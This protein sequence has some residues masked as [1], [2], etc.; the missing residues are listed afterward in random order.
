MCHVGNFPLSFRPSAGWREERYDFHVPGPATLANLQVGPVTN[1]RY[2]ALPG[3]S[4]HII[5][6]ASARA[7]VAPDGGDNEF[8]A[9]VDGIDGL[10]IKLADGVPSGEAHITDYTTIAGSE[11]NDTLGARCSQTHGGATEAQDIVV[12]YWGYYYSP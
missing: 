9:V 1:G 12:S 3:A 10:P 6:K 8:R 2:Q 7:Y 4:G 11:L 5:A